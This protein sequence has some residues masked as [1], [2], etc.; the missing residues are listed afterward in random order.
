MRPDDDLRLYLAKAHRQGDL[1]A[2]ADA[3]RLRAPQADGRT[4][5]SRIGRTFIRLGERLAAEPAEPNLRPARP[6]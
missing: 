2:A 3:R 4:I 5:R 1:K 6:H